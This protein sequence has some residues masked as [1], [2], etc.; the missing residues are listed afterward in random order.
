MPKGLIMANA[1][2]RLGSGWGS[3]VWAVVISRAAL[4]KQLMKSTA[5]EAGEKE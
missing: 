4:G 3:P 5:K 1:P 2:P